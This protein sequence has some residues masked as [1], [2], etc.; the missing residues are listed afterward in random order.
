[1]FCKQYSTTLHFAMHQ[2]TTNWLHCVYTLITQSLYRFLAFI[3][4]IFRELE[5]WSMC[6]VRIKCN[7]QFGQCVLCTLSVI[8]S[9]VNVC[10]AH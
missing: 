7:L 9:L 1:M 5:V 10:C 3:L 6:V 8:C 4:A 2:F